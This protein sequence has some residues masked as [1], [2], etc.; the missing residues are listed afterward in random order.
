M[1]FQSSVSAIFGSMLSKVIKKKIE[2]R[3]KQKIL[4]ARQCD[5]LAAHISEVCKCPISASTLKRL[6][7]F[8]KKERETRPREWTLDLLSQ[9]CGYETWS[10]LQHE[11][12]GNVQKKKSRIESV[13]CLLLK[14]GTKLHVKFG[15]FVF[16]ELHYE[17]KGCFIVT[18]ANKSTLIINDKLEIE[19]IKL[20]RPVLVRKLIRNGTTSTDLIV[21]DLTGVTEITSDETADKLKSSNGILTNKK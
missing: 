8:I 11:L 2:E 15:R 6:W 4:Y 1:A 5:S 19:S 13:N 12:A 10:D 21:G 18:G 17:G 7:G 20:D 16:I 14:P 3:Y 9:Y